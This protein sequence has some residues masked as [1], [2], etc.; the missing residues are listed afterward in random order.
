MDVGYHTIRQDYFANPDALV[1]SWNLSTGAT[2]DLDMAGQVST[3]VVTRGDANGKGIR[4]GTVAGISC[5]TIRLDGVTVTGQVTCTY[6]EAD[7]CNFSNAASSTLPNL[8]SS[9]ISNSQISSVSTV[10]ATN[11]V[12]TNVTLNCVMVSTGSARLRDVNSQYSVRLYPASNG[13][14][15]N[16]SWVGGSAYKID[17]D[18]TLSAASNSLL[19]QAYNVEITS[20]VALG[21]GINVI[22][23]GTK[24]WAI[25]GHYNVR[26]GN[27]EGLYTR[28]TFGSAPATLVNVG[29]T[30]IYPSAYSTAV[31]CFRSDAAVEYAQ[32]RVHSVYL[33]R[34]VV[35]LYTLSPRCTVASTVPIFPHGGLPHFTCVSTGN[36]PTA[37]DPLTVNFE[38]YP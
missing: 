17:F 34:G 24:A 25:N 14:F 20:L 37:G 36:T 8:T 4:N 38:M 15:A 19:Y 11:A 33:N 10:N 1:K 28:R 30:S 27:N 6:V 26:V 2:G 35:P 23:G 18:A 32:G 21:G 3:V 22:N 16:F 7:R 13:K 5:S 29:S 12:W 9:R 31:L